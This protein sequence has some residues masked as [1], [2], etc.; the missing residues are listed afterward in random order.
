[1]AENRDKDESEEERGFTISDR[2]HWAHQAPG[3]PSQAE[4]EAAPTPPA[5]EE[6]P[7]R[8]EEVSPPEA[9]TPPKEA[10]VPPEEL[11]AADLSYVVVFLAAQAML[12][13]GEQPDPTTGETMEKNLPGAK[14][15]IDL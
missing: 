3:E 2:R 7:P 10:E 14:H 15:A 13:M 6:A 11:P 8:T 4:P 1:M 9:A 12:C 5:E